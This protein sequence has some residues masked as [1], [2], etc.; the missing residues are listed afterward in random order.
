MLRKTLTLGSRAFQN[1]A[2]KALFVLYCLGLVA[3]LPAE[4][5]PRDCKIVEYNKRGKD[6]YV[7]VPGKMPIKLA[8]AIQSFDSFLEAKAGYYVA[9]H[10]RVCL[11]PFEELARE[12]ENDFESFFEPERHEPFL[13]L[14]D[15]LNVFDEDEDEIFDEL[16]PEE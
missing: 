7:V 15:R 10:K 11:A 14:L 6:V 3:T 12:I 2:L 9:I 8:A 16:S 1:I 4:A 13:N 5:K